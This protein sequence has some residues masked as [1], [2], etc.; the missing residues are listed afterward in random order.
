MSTTNIIMS[1][2]QSPVSAAGLVTVLY[3]FCVEM[4]LDLGLRAGND[5]RDNSSRMLLLRGW[6]LG[7]SLRRCSKE[8]R[9]RS[10]FWLDSLKRA[11]A[12]WEKEKEGCGVSWRKDRKREKHQL[13]GPF[14][15]IDAHQQCRDQ[16]HLKSTQLL[17]AAFLRVLVLNKYTNECTQTYL[18]KSFFFGDF[19]RAQKFHDILGSLCDSRLYPGVVTQLLHPQV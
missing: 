16:F 18:W 1:S 6:F 3:W 4:R 14:Y 13:H 2:V 8:Y 12:W 7:N 15:F 5:S 17:R 9:R 10:S 19:S 11:W